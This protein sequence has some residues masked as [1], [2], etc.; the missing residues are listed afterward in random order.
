MP[1]GERPGDKSE[2]R[3][4]GVET[5]FS[6][7]MPNVLA[8]NLTHG[9]FDF[10]VATLVRT[11]FFSISYFILLVSAFQFLE[12]VDVCLMVTN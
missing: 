11:A 1:L 2:S 7:D 3:Y 8:F 4:C 6:D 9:S 12:M 10:V 5:E